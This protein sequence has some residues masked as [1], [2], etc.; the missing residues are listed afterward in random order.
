MYNNKKKSMNP[1]EK[2]HSMSQV[3]SF[4][5]QER[6]MLVTVFINKNNRPRFLK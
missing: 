4:E 3:D 5:T 6:I 1:K 2:D